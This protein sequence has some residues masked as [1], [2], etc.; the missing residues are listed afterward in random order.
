LGSFCPH[1]A[2]YSGYRVAVEFRIYVKGRF[3][4]TIFRPTRRSESPPPRHE[5]TQNVARIPK[6]TRVGLTNGLCTQGKSIIL[7]RLTRKSPRLAQNMSVPLYESTY[8]SKYYSR[9]EI[10]SPTSSKLV[11]NRPESLRRQ[12]Q[13]TIDSTAYLSIDADD[14]IS[15]RLAD[16]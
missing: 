3:A 8:F 4:H 16:A 12:Q 11:Q 6:S 15:T 5:S 2:V 1:D 14:V 10:I 13:H 7:S 9:Q